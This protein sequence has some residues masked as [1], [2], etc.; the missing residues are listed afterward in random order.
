LHAKLNRL[1]GSA[2]GTLVALVLLV[3]VV[4][5]GYW[6][7]GW[8]GAALEAAGAEARAA[9]G[10]AV[11][12]EDNGIHTG[13]V[14]P[15]ALLTPRLA[16]RFVAADLRDPRYA[17]HDWVAV[18]WGDRA[19]YLDTPTW[20]DLSLSTVAA[21]AVGSDAT[22]LHVEHVP[23]PIAGGPVK[24]VLLRPDQARRLV[25]FIDASLGEGPADRGY[26]AWDAFYPARGHYSAVRTC[27]A[28]T[29]EAL[30]AA[31]VPMGRWTPFSGTVMWWL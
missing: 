29:G 11:Y 6:I 16:G 24:R 28:W 25:G 9:S 14:V 2:L 19:F 5:Q 27:N 1:K 15:K 21:A 12:V 7:A 17:R 10:I 4:A 26:D 31:G 8:I 20:R 18:G 13:I 22:V 3:A 23:P 30:V